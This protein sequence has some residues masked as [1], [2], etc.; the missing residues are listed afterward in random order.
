MFYIDLRFTYILLSENKN[1]SSKNLLTEE[2]LSVGRQV[3]MY[4]SHYSESTLTWHSVDICHN[5]RTDGQTAQPSS[6]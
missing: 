5:E 2:Q 1:K 4:C 3:H 6:Y